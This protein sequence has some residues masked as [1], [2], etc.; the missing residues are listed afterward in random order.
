MKRSLRT[1]PTAKEAS[2]FTH[3][4]TING[5]ADQVAVTQT[6]DGWDGFYRTN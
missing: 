5:R 4:A 6:Y 2:D 1:R 3:D